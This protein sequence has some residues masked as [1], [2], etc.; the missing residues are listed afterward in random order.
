MMIKNARRTAVALALVAFG[1]VTAQAQTQTVAFSVSAINQIAFTGTPTLAIT[2]ATAGLNPTPA[3]DASARWAVTTNTNGAKVTA[4]IATVMPTGLTLSAGLA[5]PTGG[6][7]AG[8]QALGTTA[9]D[10]VTGISYLAEGALVVTYKLDALP[11][12]VAVAS[13]SKIVTYTIVSGT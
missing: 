11:T 9:V 6:S 10:L 2:T 4:S 3:T 1:A 5:Q 8:L 13:G 7:T 12:A